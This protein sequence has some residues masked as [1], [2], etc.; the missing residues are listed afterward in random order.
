MMTAAGGEAL[1]VEDVFSTYLYEGTNTTNTINNGIDLDGESG[2][3]W[4]KNR[5]QSDNHYIFGGES[6]NNWTKI[7]SPNGNGF[8]GGGTGIFDGV[9]STGFTVKSDFGGVNTNGENYVSWTFRKAPKFFDVVTWTGDGTTGRQIS[10]NLD[11]TVGM[12]ILKRTDSSGYW[13]VYHRGVDSTS[14]EDYTLILNSTSGRIDEQFFI[15]D[16]AP[17]STHFTVGAAAASGGDFNT[18]GATY[19]AYLFAHHDGDGKF[20]PT[21][22]QDIIK[23]GSYTGNGSTDGPEIDLGFEPQW[24]LVKSDGSANWVIIDSM[25]GIVSDGSDK[26]IMP[27]GSDVEYE[28]SYLIGGN[29]ANLLPTGFKITEDNATVNG[30]SNTYIYMAIRRGPMAVPESATDVFDV[31]TRTGN[32]TNT[33]V[34][35]N[36]SFTS[37][38]I[39]TKERG[40]GGGNSWVA[41]RLR[42]I[43]NANQ[44]V[45]FLNSTAA[46]STSFSSGLR[47]AYEGEY[48]VGT[49][50]GMNNSGDT[51]VDWHWKRA[52]NFFDVVAYTGNGTAGR[53]VSHNLGVAPEMMWVK[54]RG[55]TNHWAV[56]HKGLNGGIDPEDYYIRLNLTNAEANSASYW[57]DTAPTDSAFTVAGATVVNRSGG[58][59]IAYLFA[60]LD[61][62]SKVGSYTGNGTNQNI[63][64]GFS[65][66]AR[67]VLIKGTNVADWYLFDSERGIVSGGDPVLHLN[68]TL[69][70]ISSYDAVDPYSG[71]FKVNQ[72]TNLPV[73]VSGQ[74]YIFYA[75]A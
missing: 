54:E 17:T 27:N 48:E 34:T 15:N 47:N 63:D 30:N 55:N 20:G 6:G 33:T 16:T 9:S 60:S 12:M 28:S 67:F 45:L 72:V 26:I 7:L 37:D 66:G 42:G 41:D 50:S 13:G 68:S 75:I 58:T 56:Y 51:F 38:W 18:N 44:G 40:S 46:E 69:A 43:M 14:P 5:D 19:I 11:H 8:Y 39:I 35:M 22:D 1:N 73:N 64:C 62:V 25:R 4:I 10:H 61:G 29:M 24:L 74:T 23:C 57:N 71:G 21:G 36:Q 49:T 52:P 70:E 65:S 31:V 53:T 3:V 2:I 59:Y 32:S